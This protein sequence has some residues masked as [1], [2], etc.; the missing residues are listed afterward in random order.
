MIDGF[1][2]LVD[3]A[4]GS[5]GGLPRTPFFLEPPD[6]TQPDDVLLDGWLA[7]LTPD[8]F[9][10]VLDSLARPRMATSASAS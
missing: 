5:E 9:A 4:H 3:G 1:L 2:G 7:S 6:V 8:Q 10:H